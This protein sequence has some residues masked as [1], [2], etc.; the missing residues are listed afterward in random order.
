MTDTVPEATIDLRPLTPKARAARGPAK[1]GHFQNGSP[2][3]ESAAA[4]LA[5]AQ[6]GRRGPH[7][8]VCNHPDRA[9]IEFAKIS[10]RGLHEVANEFGVHKDSLWRHMRMH[11]TEQTKIGYLAGPVKLAE[12]ANLAAS[13]NKSLIEYLSILRS[14]LFGQLD[15]S[16]QR[17]KPFEVERISGRALDTLREIGRLTG[18]LSAFTSQNINVVNNQTLVM[19]SP[20]VTELQAALLETLAP[21]EEARRAVIAMFVRLDE[22]HRGSDMPQAPSGMKLI[23]AGPIS[24]S[25]AIKAGQAAKREREAMHA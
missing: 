24:R 6:R 22:R 14:V 18:E 21:Y 25:D 15:R 8:Q 16:A 11:V 19:N 20:I 2:Y 10:G 12:L 1:P 3:P 7:C 13:E 4:R 5:K 9:R 23:E 17:N